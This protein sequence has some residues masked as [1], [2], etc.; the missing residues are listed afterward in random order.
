MKITIV[1]D[2]MDTVGNLTSEYTAG[3]TYDVSTNIA[4]RAAKARATL[5]PEA[6]ALAK[7]KP[8]KPTKHEQGLNKEQAVKIETLEAKIKTLE[9]KLQEQLDGDNSGDLD[10]ETKAENERLVSELDAVRDMLTQRDADLAS[11]GESFE[12]E[13]TKASALATRL[14]ECDAEIVTLKSDLEA[15]T[16][17][18]QD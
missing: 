4:V 10:A 2:W 18:K 6:V 16:A 3:V 14:E 9:D 7:V 15:A 5:H 8:L 12:Q 11:A 17:P 1:Q 13:R